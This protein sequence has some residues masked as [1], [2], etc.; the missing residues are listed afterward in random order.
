MARQ[1]AAMV[2]FQ[3]RG[4]VVFD[5]GNSLRAE[6]RT[7]G[8]DEAFAYPG[9]VEAYVRPLFCQGIGPFRWAALSGD[10]ADIA[11]TDRAIVELFPENEGL[12]RWMRMAKER[13]AFQGLPARICWLGYGERHRAGLR[14]NELVRSGEVDGADRHRP[15]PP[16]LGLGRVAVP[17]DRGDARRIRRDRRLAAPERDAERRRRALPGWRCTTE[18]ASASAARSTRAR[19]SW[20]TARDEG[21]FRVERVLTNDPGTGVMRHAD[22]GYEI[23]LEHARATGLDLPMLP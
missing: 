3:E 15:G 10:P 14:I 7:A 19:R 8:F 5:Y 22:A 2:R 16:R 9:F 20:P 12:Q 17:R 13:I 11:A 1:C 6:A 21:A 23:A 18:A 4:S